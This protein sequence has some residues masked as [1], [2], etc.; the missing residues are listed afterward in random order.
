[1]NTNNVILG[2]TT[3]ALQRC[4]YIVLLT[5]Y[6]VLLSWLNQTFTNYYNDRF[7]N[8]FVFVAQAYETGNVSE[9]CNDVLNNLRPHFEVTLPLKKKMEEITQVKVDKTY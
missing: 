2:K 8:N 1:M 9:K 5:R 3:N 7:F 6:L 4:I